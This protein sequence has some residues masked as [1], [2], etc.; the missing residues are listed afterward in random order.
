MSD[1]DCVG[2]GDLEHEARIRAAFIRLE[3]DGYRFCDVPACN[4]GQYHRPESR[5]D[6]G[7]WLRMRACVP[8][9]ISPRGQHSDCLTLRNAADAWEREQE[10]K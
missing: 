7:D 1:H 2:C 3:T 8:R 6:V 9:C 5:Q 10:G 4:C